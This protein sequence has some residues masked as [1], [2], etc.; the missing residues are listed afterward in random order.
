[1]SDQALAILLPIFR[2]LAGNQFCYGQPI[3]IMSGHRTIEVTHQD[4][5]TGLLHIAT[6]DHD[7]DFAA[8]SP[9]TASSV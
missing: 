1:M 9:E 7:A 5:F 2:C 8:V 4:A 3:K 6:F